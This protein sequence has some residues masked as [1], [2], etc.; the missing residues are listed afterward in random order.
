MVHPPD[1]MHKND[2]SV[3]AQLHIGN[4]WVGVHRFIE[5][6]PEI[7]GAADV[8]EHIEWQQQ[9]QLDFAVHVVQRHLFDVACGLD[10]T[11]IPAQALLYRVTQ[12]QCAR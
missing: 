10:L 4:L 8:A 3:E 7:L 1:I 12:R 2:A 5:A 9:L 11:E 6:P